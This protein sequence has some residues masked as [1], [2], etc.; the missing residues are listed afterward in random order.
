[1][2]QIT[3]LPC[4]DS[5][6]HARTVRAHLDIARDEA[7]RLGSTAVQCIENGFYLDQKGSR[8]DWSA[9]V[10]K[11]RI[12]KISI[13]PEQ[14]LPAMPEHHFEETRVQI[15]NETTL[16]AA[17]KLAQAGMAPLAL[18][19]ANGVEPGGGFLRGARAQEESLC[20][21]SALYATLAGD[22]MYEAHRKRPQPDSTDW[23]IYSPDVPVFRSD[24]GK[25]LETPWTLNFLT[26]AAPYAPALNPETAA[27]LLRGR[28]HRVLSIARAYRHSQLVLGAWGCGAFG[29]D[30]LRTANDFRNALETSFAGAFSTVIFA[31]SDWSVER[32]FL[33]PFRDTFERPGSP[34]GVQ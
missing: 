29:N 6:K 20:R 23:A 30:P 28:I 13:P 15:S 8:V 7:V 22:P 1:M 16:S 33:G 25:E 2:P 3:F 27:A 34:T 5:E 18:N 32:R 9:A 12:S 4:L 17:W 24:D 11:A 10:S 26:C 14:D 31:I 19:L 21:S